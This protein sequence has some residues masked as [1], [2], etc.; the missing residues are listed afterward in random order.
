MELDVGLVVL[1]IAVVLAVLLAQQRHGRRHPASTTEVLIVTLS[2]TPTEVE[3]FRNTLSHLASEHG[4]QSSVNG[5][6][7]LELVN[8]SPELV[9]A[10]AR[11]DLPDAQLVTI[12][13]EARWGTHCIRCGASLP[14]DARFCTHCGESRSTTYIQKT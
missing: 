5:D 7:H 11:V 1:G 8:P 3:R 13:L 2:G 9:D 10:L 12:E 6:G 14:Q 4:V